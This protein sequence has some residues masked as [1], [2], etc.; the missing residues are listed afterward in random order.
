[1]SVE[2]NNV[3]DNFDNIKYCENFDTY[4]GV[5]TNAVSNNLQVLFS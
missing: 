3:N 1:M 5:A 2:F 4:Q